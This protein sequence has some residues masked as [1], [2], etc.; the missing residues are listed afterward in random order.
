MR[1]HH[2]QVQLVLAPC[3][4]ALDKKGLTVAFSD[5][6]GLVLVGRGGIETDLPLDAGFFDAMAFM[7]DVQARAR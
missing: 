6:L 7:A 4:P 2:K 3:A 5:V 1:I